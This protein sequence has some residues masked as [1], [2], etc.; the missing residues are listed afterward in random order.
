MTT[1]AE[2]MTKMIKGSGMSPEELR[3]V[4]AALTG[5]LVEKPTVA[6]FLGQVT[7]AIAAADESEERG[8]GTLRTFM[9]HFRLM[10]EG[11]PYTPEHLSR[12][13]DG[14][15]F[16]VP[17]EERLYEGLG[18]MRLDEVRLS[19]LLE[20]HKWAE[21]RAV[22]CQHDRAQR[23]MRKGKAVRNYTGAG[24][25]RTFLTAMRCFFGLAIAVKL[26]AEDPAKLLP[27]PGIAESTRHAFTHDELTELW[28]AACT[29]P[30]AVLA[31]M[32]F[33][34]VL[35]TGA[36]RQGLKA[37]ELRDLDPERVSVVLREKKKAIEQPATVE[38]IDELRAFAASRG[39]TKPTDPVF[40]QRP[41]RRK[42]PATRITGRVIDTVNL[43]LQEPTWA[44]RRGV[45]IHEIRHHAIT[46]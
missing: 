2:L 45:T 14:H 43:A 9:P 7:K 10:V 33:K 21:K 8:G 46:K 11:Y 16:A 12:R 35:I 29:A 1:Q 40:C 6:E 41:T 34:T 26:L 5:D 15:R 23:R 39:S 37:L 17:A 42:P 32:V 19:H 25:S 44:D 30:D 24:A 36:R 22:L 27:D 3:D 38:L 4:A 13:P 28:A 31:V 20:A 18:D